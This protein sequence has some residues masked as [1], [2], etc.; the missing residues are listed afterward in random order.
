MQNRTTILLALDGIGLN[1][2]SENNAVRKA[3]T[4]NFDRILGEYPKTRILGA[5]MAVGLPGG[6]SGNACA[7]FSNMGAGRIVYQDLVRIKKDIDSGAFYE[8]EVL[9][10]TVSY[11]KRN[12]SCLHLIGLVSDGGVHSHTD[13]LYA[14]LELAKRN[15]I[16]RVYVHCITD[17]RDTPSD[18]GMSY[19]EDLRVKMRE[20]GVGEIASVSGR[21]YAMDRDNN[22]DRVKIAYLA[23]TQGEGFK[24]ANPAEAIQNAYER[25][26][27]DEFIKP[28][29][30]VNGGVPVGMINDDDAVIFF[31]YRTDRTRELTRAFCENEFR[32]FKREKRLDILFINMTDPDPAIENNYAVYDHALT[33]R[34]LGS[35]LQECGLSQLRITESEVFPT[36]IQFFDCGARENYENGDRVIIRSH[37]NVESYAE[38]PGMNAAAITDRLV[39]GIASGKYDFILCNLPN[40]DVV[41]HTGDMQATVRAVEEV[42]VCLGRIYEQAMESGSV[43]ILCSSHGNAEEMFDVQTKTPITC[44]TMN[45]VPFVV[46]NCDHVK[47]LAPVGSLADVAPTILDIMGLECP[48]EMSGKSLVV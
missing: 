29:V 17:G 11:C 7:G 40:A 13:H 3:S 35:Y 8:N 45:P 21:Y 30:V 9:K 28:T 33:E 4:P 46:A 2:S 48:K 32:Q 44:N 38:K 20:I 12:D 34:T 39:S 25:G 26:E 37:K 42:D 6:M 47:N 36:V 16:R 19:I 10:E 1:D 31:N 43:L 18:K 22:Y 27:T 5:G 23:M 15:D 14:L 24:A 41:G